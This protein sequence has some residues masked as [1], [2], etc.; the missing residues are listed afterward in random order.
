MQAIHLPTLSAEGLRIV[1]IKSNS[2][3]QLFCERCLSGTIGLRS[4]RRQF[5]PCLYLAAGL[6]RVQKVL[7][8]PVSDLGSYPRPPPNT[9]MNALAKSRMAN[10]PLQMNHLPPPLIHPPQLSD[11]CSTLKGHSESIS[12]RRL[13]A[14]LE[15]S[16][17][18]NAKCRFTIFVSAPFNKTFISRDLLSLMGQF[19]RLVTQ[20]CEGWAEPLLSTRETCPMLMLPSF[21]RTLLV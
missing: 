13:S 14:V 9:P 5:L 6:T 20:P 21:P 3:V 17:D 11:P 8:S 7:A 2:G 16:E 10:V 19:A 12:H 15:A 4:I 1:S 18:Q